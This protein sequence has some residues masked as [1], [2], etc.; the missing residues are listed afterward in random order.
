MIKIHTPDI[1][2]L[3]IDKTIFLMETIKQL[4]LEINSFIIAIVHGEPYETIIYIWIDI[5]YSQG[6]SSDTAAQITHRAI[7]LF[8][9]NVEKN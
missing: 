9:A 8:L 6:K 2:D 7:R 5:L 4:G 3:K 1:D